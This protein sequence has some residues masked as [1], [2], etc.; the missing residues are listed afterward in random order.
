MS[1]KINDLVTQRDTVSD[2]LEFIEDQINS[3]GVTVNLD[4]NT[5]EGYIKDLDA[6]KA[7]ID[8]IH[9]QIRAANPPDMPIHKQAYFIILR[10]I[11]KFQQE[12]RGIQATIP[13]ITRNTG[14]GGIPQN[15]P[16]V[17]LPKLQIPAF[18]GDILEWSSFK[19]TFDSAIGNNPDLSKVQKFTYL[20]TLVKGEALRHIADLTLT[21][22]NYD[23]AYQQL[24]DRYQNK[25][26]ITMALLDRLRSIPKSNG[27]AR[28][29]KDIADIAQRTER[30]LQILGFSWEQI[31]H[32]FFLHEVLSKIDAT[33]REWWEH[34]LKGKD[35]PSTMDLYEFL[36]T[37]ATSLE[38]Y[39]DLHGKRTRPNH[40]INCSN[41]CRQDHP[42]YRCDK[43]KELS[44]EKRVE[45]IK[46]FGNCA[47]CLNSGHK[48]KDCTNSNRCYKCNKPHHTL[49]HID[50][51]Y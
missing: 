43:F 47:N 8:E 1:K 14:G 25:R 4:Y 46:L 21:D 49:L 27:T 31:A 3:H 38:E 7:S 44:V 10:E 17:S 28:S 22:A 41:G 5:I 30:S 42:L 15:K 29:I 45:Q 24:H 16:S 6:D 40:P 18:H 33:T 37:H 35:V 39:S 11:S 32:L 20:K 2:H 50:N 19:D 13:P 51:N 48:T 23:I 26:K 9:K 12:L 36:E 34:T